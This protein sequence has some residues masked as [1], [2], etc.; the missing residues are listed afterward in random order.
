[1]HT[2]NCLPAYL[3]ANVPTHKPTDGQIFRPANVP[4]YRPAHLPKHVS[5]AMKSQTQTTNHDVEMSVRQLDADT[6]QDE[7]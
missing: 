6:V 2:P 7:C 1:M 5:C 3:R 4:T